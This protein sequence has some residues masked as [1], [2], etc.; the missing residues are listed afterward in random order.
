MV[1]VKVVDNQGSPIA[2]IKV[3]SVVDKYTLS[4]AI[5]GG[6]TDSNGNVK[7]NISSILARDATPLRFTVCLSSVSN[8]QV[9]FLDQPRY[10]RTG[11]WRNSIETPYATLCFY[12]TNELMVL[13]VSVKRKRQKTC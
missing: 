1:W 3:V 7:F 5:N 6:V 13:G 8:N 11:E 9:R 12:D 4:N 2:G 10:V